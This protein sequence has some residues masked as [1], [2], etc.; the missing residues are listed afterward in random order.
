MSCTDQ[1]KKCRKVNFFF[2]SKVQ[3]MTV[4]FT[5][6]LVEDWIEKRTCVMCVPKKGDLIMCR[7]SVPQTKR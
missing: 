5:V 7:Q 1:D 3:W 6:A 4:G 2:G